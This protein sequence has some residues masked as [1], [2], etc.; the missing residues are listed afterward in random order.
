MEHHYVLVLSAF[1]I[2]LLLGDPRYPLHPIRL[3]GH[4][5]SVY[6]RKLRAARL[7]GYR[8]GLLHGLLL[9]ATA[10]G[11]WWGTRTLLHSSS[12]LAAACWDVL[13]AWHLLSLKDLLRHAARVQVSLADLTEARRR[14]GWMVG[15]D[16]ER[17]DRAAVVR[18]TIE[19]LS[20]SLTDGVLTP[21]WALCLGGMPALIVVKVVSTLDSMVGYK[22][23]RYRRFGW[24][25]ARSDDLVNWLP[26]RLAV[27]VVAAAATLLRLHP[28]DAV[29]CARR[30]HGLLTSPNSGWTECAYAGALRVRLAGPIFHNGQ[31]V[32]AMYIGDPAWPQDLDGNH[33]RTAMHL[34]LLCGWLGLALGLAMAWLMGVR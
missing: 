26:A 23:A 11:A 9:M 32:C 19:S 2:D 12:P 20:E 25:A 8:G 1:G 34:T 6:E 7:G 3:L 17:M 15:R 5:C 27:L 29:R 18:A 33:L 31:Q 21:L 30:Q 16:T 4:L 13:L 14:V 28:G 22:T 24:F 10:L